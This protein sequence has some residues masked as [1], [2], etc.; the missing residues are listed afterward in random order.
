MADE[1]WGNGVQEE[2]LSTHCEDIFI[3]TAP[4]EYQ[5]KKAW[6]EN[7]P[8]KDRVSIEIKQGN[9]VFRSC[10]VNLSPNSPIY[11]RAVSL[12]ED[13]AKSHLLPYKVKTVEQGVSRR[14]FPKE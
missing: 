4:K 3:R 5:L 11:K 6:L 10:N 14:L 7:D 9:R 2:R 1:I 12:V 13:L 8:E